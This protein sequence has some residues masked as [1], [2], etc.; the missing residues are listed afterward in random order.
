MRGSKRAGMTSRRPARAPRCCPASSVSIRS[1][2]TSRRAISSS[3]YNASVASS[4]AS[5]ILSARSARASGLRRQSAI[6]LALSHQASSLWSSQ[7]LV[8]AEEHQVGAAATASRTR[9]SPESPQ[10]D[11][12]SSSPLPTSCRQGSPRSRARA[13]S[14]LGF[15]RRHEA[16]LREVAAVHDEDG[17]GV[18]AD[19]RLVVG[20]MR[21]IGGAHLAEARAAPREN[22]GDAEGTAD[23]DQLAPADDDLLPGGHGVERQHQGPGRVVH[24]QRV[25]G[26]GE[27]RELRAAVIGATAARAAVQVELE[28]AVAGRDGL[29]RADR[30]GRERRAA[31]VGVQHDAGG[32]DDAR[33]R[34]VRCGLQQ[35]RRSRRPSRRVGPHG[36]SATARSP[37]APQP[38]TAFRGATSISSSTADRAAGYRPTA[39]ARRLSSLISSGGAAF[40]GA[41][42]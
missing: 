16:R 24:H 38:T 6:E 20:E 4:A 1:T 22:V 17:A 14:A 12:S 8:A 29:D 25:G 34:W 39:A 18:G 9:G 2:G 21:A 11:R 27:P 35:A 33:E 26:A 10:G 31:E 23:L 30:G 5:V 32:V 36:A 19:R 3:S 15:G 40:F 28:G 37:R 7:Q 41:G 42:A 13:A